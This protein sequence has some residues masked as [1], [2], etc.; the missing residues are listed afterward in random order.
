MGLEAPPPGPA[1]LIPRRLLIAGFPLPLPPNR[2][3]GTLPSFQE[4]CA[5]D[6]KSYYSTWDSSGPWLLVPVISIVSLRV[7]FGRK[8]VAGGRREGNE[9]ETAASRSGG[10]AGP[11]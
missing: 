10:R 2:D 3:Q 6:N 7:L 1:S 11:Q 4:F 9:A 5:S 8:A